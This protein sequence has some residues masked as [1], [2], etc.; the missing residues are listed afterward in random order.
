MA[1]KVVIKGE[2][3]GE[4]GAVTVDEKRL[5]FNRDEIKEVRRGRRGDVTT[6]LSTPRTV[7][8]EQSGAR[9]TDQKAHRQEGGEK[10]SGAFFVGAWICWMKDD[11]VLYLHA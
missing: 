2:T 7:V 5:A 11:P 3:E 1:A 4:G 8:E 9:K 10:R 6:C